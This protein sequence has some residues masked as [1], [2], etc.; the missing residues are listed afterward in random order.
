MD[1]A[2]FFGKTLPSLNAKHSQQDISFLFMTL[3]FYGPLA[4]FDS[5][6]DSRQVLLHD[7]LSDDTNN[8]AEHNKPLSSIS[9]FLQI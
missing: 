9:D 6:R 1:Q 2:C 7:K 4:V 5:S 8:Q 3:T